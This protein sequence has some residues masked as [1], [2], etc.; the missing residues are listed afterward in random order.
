MIFAKRPSRSSVAMMRARSSSTTT[1]STTSNP[2]SV[3]LAESHDAFVFVSSPRVS[4]GPMHKTAQVI[5]ATFGNLCRVNHAAKG[6]RILAA[7]SLILGALLLGSSGCSMAIAGGAQPRMLDELADHDP[8]RADAIM[9]E[10]LKTPD[11]KLP[12]KVHSFTGLM[13]AERGA[14]RLSNDD[15]AASATDL[16]AADKILDEKD[17]QL[18]STM[19]H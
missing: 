16:A 4:S 9:S 12:D 2:R 1:S 3:R 17:L 14:V 19:H 13:L 18:D 10:A 15:P 6:R 5:L 8:G 11:G 7:K